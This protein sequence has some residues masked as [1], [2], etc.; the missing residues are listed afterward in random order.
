[1]A[2]FLILTTLL[3]A[4]VFFI[5]FHLTRR[6][7]QSISLRET[8]LLT[9]AA[10]G[11]LVVFA[12]EGLSLLTALTPTAAKVLWASVFL[13]AS[14]WA[15]FLMIR[16]KESLAAFGKEIR[17]RF[18][19]LK[20][21]S[22]SFYLLILLI[23]LTVTALLLII[24]QY[25]VPNN[26]D[27]MRYHLARVARWEQ[28]ASVRHFATSKIHQ[29]SF[30]PFSEYAILQI[31]LLV[32][33][34]HL[35]RLVQWFALLICIIGVSEFAKKLEANPRQQLIAA[36]LC[37]SVPMV[38]L[39]A[40]STQNDL[41]AAAWLTCFMVFAFSFIREPRNLFWAAATGL[42][43]GLALLTKSTVFIFALPISLWIAILV[44]RAEGLRS[45]V[46]RAGVVIVLA[47]AMVNLGHF[48]R[49]TITFGNPL[50]KDANTVNENLSLRGMA[51]NA[52]RNIQLNVPETGQSNYK[53]INFIS[54]KLTALSWKLHTFTGLDS[55]DPRFTYRTYQ[56]FI[57]P[58]GLSRDEGTAGS[59]VHLIMIFLSVP[60]SFLVVKKRQ[61]KQLMIV[62]TSSFLLFCFLLKTQT[63]INRL[64]M[65][66]I[67]LWVPVLA[68]TLFRTH[69]I[70][71]VVFPVIV[72]ALSLPW[73]VNN[74]T[75]PLLPDQERSIANWPAEGIEAYFLRDPK[76]FPIYNEIS[77]I[78]MKEQCT[79]IGIYSRR[80]FFEYPFW[81]VMN[82]QDSSVEIR[83]VMISNKSKIYEDPNYLPCAIVS[84]IELPN[85]SGYFPQSIDGFWVHLEN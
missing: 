47:V 74:N 42:A 44:I 70:G 17:S 26:G 8:F 56:G 25:P 23:V 4:A 76:L 14:G 54:T 11:L 30:P 24:K 77:S 68:V 2:I 22:W 72:W 48:T 3:F 59:F 34:D 60:I 5:I 31:K 67:V 7:E 32:G 9:A 64:D 58:L 65:P 49:N 75:R 12:T 57:K 29:I 84:D 79:E 6:G 71:W 18:G 15:A 40:T 66:L 41:V 36:L 85:L 61:I 21:Q 20:T 19:N 55:N 81:M 73:V 10:I 46:W 28:Q 43:L 83:H 63:P 37:A 27:S 62:L 78:I 33:N 1:M 53:I 69:R 51:A 35:S 52:I 82:D 39:Q 50:G 13:L 38:I 16:R 45:V 80:V